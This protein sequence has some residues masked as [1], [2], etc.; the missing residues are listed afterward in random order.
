MSAVLTPVIDHVVVSVGDRLDEA[1]ETYRRLGFT[2]TERGHHSLGSSNHL[3][4][5]G[6]DYLELLGHEP[7]RLQGAAPPWQMPDGLGGLVFKP[8]PTEDF[9]RRIA[10][11]GVPVG[12]SR[13]FARP[14]ALPGGGAR[15][16]RFRVTHL[17]A[18]ASLGGRVFF[19]H[20]HTPE[21]VWRQEW[22]RHD[23]AVTGVAE[24]GVTSGEPARTAAHYRALFGKAVAEIPGGVAIAA[25]GARVLILTPEA[26]RARWGRALPRLPSDGRER[27]VALGLRSARLEDSRDLLRRSG[28]RPREK[29]GRLLLPAAETGGL[30]LSFSG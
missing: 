17:A 8:L 5:F 3:A 14:V 15:E 10:E 2:L 24:F 19:C 29:E 4:V 18:G 26:A 25:A 20:H 6:T 30:A 22:Q 16:A 7:A 13:D 21:L 28:F 9:A 1:A 11:A 12:E 27:M 23:N